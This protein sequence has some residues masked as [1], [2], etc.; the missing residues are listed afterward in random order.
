VL[1]DIPFTLHEVLLFR[2]GAHGPREVEDSEC[3]AAGGP[4]PRLLGRETEEYL[5]CFDH[6]RLKRIQA[7][8][9]LGAEQAAQ[10]F[11]GACARW[12]KNSVPPAADAAKC[13]GR[14]A[15][16]GW[17]A[18][19]VLERDPPQAALSIAVFDAAVP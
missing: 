6:D 2:D 8:V 1:K 18:R 19:L 7:S 17:S 3:Y 5:L 16:I 9:V 13:E 10:T 4:P 11:S 12:L 14:E 15:D